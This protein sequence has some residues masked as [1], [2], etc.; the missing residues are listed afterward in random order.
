MSPLTWLRRRDRGLVAL[1]R[2]ARTALVMSAV[3]ALS[4]EVVGDPQ[5]ATF[6]AIG[7]FAMLMRA[8]CRPASPLGYRLC[9]R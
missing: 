7:S 9:R 6:A 8:E 2:A 1:R 5:V 4:E 3:F